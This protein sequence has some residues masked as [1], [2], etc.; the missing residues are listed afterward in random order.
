MFLLRT[1]FL[2]LACLC[3]PVLAAKPVAIV[4][5]QPISED[6]LQNEMQSHQQDRSAALD[7]LILSHLAVQQALNKGIDRLPDVKRETDKIL[8]RAFLDR[9]ILE[10]GKTIYPS[11]AEVEAFYRSKAPLIRVRILSFYAKTPEEWKDARHKADTVLH[12]AYKGADFNV[13]VYVY[14]KNGGELLHQDAA[15]H[16]LGDLPAPI[17][18]ST[19]KLKKGQYTSVE[20]ETGVHLVQ[21]V[22]RKRFS[23][24][25]AAYIEFLRGKLRAEHENV[26]VTQLL[27]R[28][29]KKATITVSAK[30]DVP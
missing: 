18:T 22:G 2:L 23:A 26:F 7:H 1:I 12:M 25:P 30:K 21:L 24:V 6:E 13:L 20:T 4:N 15:Y 8:Y 14:A 28:L 19:L 10:A 11:D 17:Y 27:E 29:K 9:S 3:V 5:G 16:G